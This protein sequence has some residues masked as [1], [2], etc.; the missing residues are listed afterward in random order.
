[1]RSCLRSAIS[2]NSILRKNRQALHIRGE[3]MKT[4]I[5]VSAVLLLTGCSGTIG[6]DTY[7][8]NSGNVVRTTETR[9]NRCTVQNSVTVLGIDLQIFDFMGSGSSSPSKVRLGYI[10]GQQQVTPLGAKAD[11]TKTYNLDTQTFDLSMTVDTGRST[12]TDRK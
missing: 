9:D 6:K 8:D 7:L 10:S 11:L 1:M 12:D 3:S 5:V 4:V 2:F